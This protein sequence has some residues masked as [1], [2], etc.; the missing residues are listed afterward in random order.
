MK[1]GSFKRRLRFRR[2][3]EWL[4]TVMV[5]LVVIL[6][7]GRL[8]ALSV[9]ERAEQMRATAQERVLS[10]SRSIEKQLLTLAERSV[11][12]GVHT[13]LDQLLSSLKLSG[14]IDPEYDFALS[15]IDA[16]GTPPRVFVSTRI[17][18]LDKGVANVV[19]I[20]PDFAQ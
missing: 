19:R 16:S 6:A 5:L 17:D 1:F 12:N 13:E 4:P 2:T 8:I 20:P 15:K 10:Y 3:S 14:V 11:Q 7:G 9:Q 18:A